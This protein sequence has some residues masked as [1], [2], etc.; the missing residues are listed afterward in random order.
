MS[1]G[2]VKPAPFHKLLVVSQVPPP[3]HGSTVMT[4]VFLETVKA[5]GADAL[6][7]DRRFSRNVREIGQFSFRK[8]VQAVGLIWRF[9]FAIITG[10]IDQCIFFST[11]R[12]FS[13]LVDF[14]LGEIVALTRIRRINYVHTVGYVELSERGP[15]W[16][17]LIRRF[18]GHFDENVV[19]GEK[20]ASDIGSW[21]RPGSIK[22]IANTPRGHSSS[23]IF[24]RQSERKLLFLSNL[25]E[26]KGADVFVDLAMHLCAYYPNIRFEL[27]GASSDAVFTDSLISR[28]ES[29][30]FRDRIAFVGSANETEKWEHLQ[31]AD[32]LLFP[33]RY[34]Y[35]AQPLTIIES[36]AVGT[37]VIAFDIGG[38]SDLVVPGVTGRLVPLG[39]LASFELAVRGL[40]DDDIEWSNLRRSARQYFVSH[41]SRD[42]YSGKW[43]ALLF[44]M[45]QQAHDT[46]M[47]IPEE[48][49][50]Q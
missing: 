31:S 46:A 7:V 20:L 21:A 44:G 4:M 49:L 35:E 17:F 16:S 6:L 12:P 14:F 27:V 25:L 9:S 43:S 30:S 37:P 48:F 39:D 34:R 28:V 42:S 3:I 13:F 29:S 19:L 8:I 32:L 47:A 36:L 38:I 50:D 22:V 18:L 10:R 41:L 2:T 26:E 24:E 23:E 45:V 11:T 15:I 1:L 5:L 40:L 33:S